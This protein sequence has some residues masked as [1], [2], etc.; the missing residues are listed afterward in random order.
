E[1][2]HTLDGEEHELRP[3]MLMIADPERAIGIAGVMGGLN[4]EMT[5]ATTD[6]LLESATFNGINTRRTAQALRARTEASTRFEKGLNPELAMRAV[7]RATR[8][9]LETAGGVADRGVSDT[10]P[11]AG[12]AP[13]IAFSQERMRRVMG[14]AFPD[15]QVMSVLSAL[16]FAVEGT[17]D[18]LV[19]TPPYWRTDV[20]IEEDVVEEVARTLGYDTVPAEPLAG[21]VPA[22]IPQSERDVREEVRDLLVRAGMQETISYTLVSRANLEQASAIPEGVEPLSVAN[23]MSREQ[24]YLRTSMRGTLLRSAATGLRQPPGNVALFEVGR[25][26]LPRKGDL[27]VEREIAIGVLAGSRGEDLWS[28]GLPTMDFFDA[29]GVLESVMDRLGVSLRIEPGQDP[30]LHPGRTARVLVDGEDIGVAG[31]LHPKTIAAY[32]F[33][34]ETVALFEIDLGALARK[35]PWLR[36]HFGAF[37]RY[38]SA[39]RDLALLVDQAVPAERLQSIIEAGQLVV[40]STLFDLFAGKGLPE[41]KKSLAFRLELQ[42]PQGTLGTEQVTK[43]MDGIVKRLER[44]TGATLRT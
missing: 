17:Q 43:A 11:G 7:R 3:P 38:P 33:P 20:A 44:E 39:V 8:L 13:R 2:F 4:S 10:F 42:S 30:L 36:R 15:E 9:I 24:E 25:V 41:G 34:V 32:D 14:V 16:G 31:E 6:V 37:S 5:D 18:G 19:V 35:T 29:K 12:P 28:Q 27:P 1:K 26:Y 21:R 40:R 23:P 22:A